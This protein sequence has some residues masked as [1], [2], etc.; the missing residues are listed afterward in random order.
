M[1]SETKLIIVNLSPGIKLL[2][3]AVGL[4]FYFGFNGTGVLLAL[5]LIAVQKIEYD[6]YEIVEETDEEGTD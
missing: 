1:D 4:A 6:E 5:I 2:V 3:A